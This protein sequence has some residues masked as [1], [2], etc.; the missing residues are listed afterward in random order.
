[1][2]AHCSYMVPWFPIVRRSL[3]ARFQEACCLVD[4][5]GSRGS[6]ASRLSVVEAPMGGGSCRVQQL[7]KRL[8]G[9]SWAGAP[10]LC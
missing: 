6:M 7:E 3:S 9:H 2:I 4:V 5:V 10:A 8:L 1:M